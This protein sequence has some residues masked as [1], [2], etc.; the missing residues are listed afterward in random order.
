MEYRVKPNYNHISRQRREYISRRY[1]K[2]TKVINES[3]WNSSS[4]IEHSLY[5]GSYGR[6]TA[7]ETSD[8]DILVELPYYEY[9]HYKNLSGNSQSKLLQVLKYAIIDVYS[10]KKVTADGQVVVIE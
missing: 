1:R 3:F 10:P 4:D 5:V 2:I 9:A 8:I 7:I 6:G